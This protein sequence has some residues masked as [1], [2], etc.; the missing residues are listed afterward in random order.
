M[1]TF[2]EFYISDKNR[3]KIIKKLSEHFDKKNCHLIEQGLYDYTEQYCKN[4]SNNL[5]LAQSIYKDCASNIIFNCDQNNP[6]IKNIKKLISKNK[7]NPYNLAFLRPEEL[8]E[9]NWIKII[10]R[11]KTTEYQLNNLPTV[12]WKPCRDCKNIHYFYRQMQ[13]RS[14]D[15]PMTTFYTCKNCGRTYKVNN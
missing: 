10:N 3:K 6:T 5:A 7:Y 11:N 9:N 2:V 15:E 4:N 13:T 12:E 8:D 14:A 1:A